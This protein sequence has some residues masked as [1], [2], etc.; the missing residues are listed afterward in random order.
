MRTMTLLL[1]F[2]ALP[3]FSAETTPAGTTATLRAQTLELLDAVTAG[4]AKVW[5]R[6]LDADAIYT[7]ED[8][9]VNRKAEMVKNIRPLPQGV[10]GNLKI[11]EFTL[12]D[13]GSVAI[14]NYLIDEDENYH[15]HVIHCQY[16]AT[17][18]WIRKNDAWRL[19]ASQV[20]AVRT[21]PP[22]MPL[23]DAQTNAYVGRYALTPDLFFEIRRG[24]TGLQS[25]RG[26]RNWEP[27]LAE[28]PDVLFNPGSPRY[29]YIVQRDGE[30]R[31]TGI[32]E[33]R[34]AWDLHWQR[35][36]AQ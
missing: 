23:S 15:G 10:S 17:D 29:R 24:E 14:T 21:D 19:L 34:E 30:G 25:K 16:R 9:T 6:L 1:A 8:G 28:A 26:A 12:I 3:L 33:R 32:V 2:L 18:T 7:A 5:E 20:L 36:S 11:L 27:I 22:A 13:R 4:D 35:E 31:V